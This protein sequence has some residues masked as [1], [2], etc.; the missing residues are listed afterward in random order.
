[1]DSHRVPDLMTAEQFAELPEEGPYR[2]E[3]KRGRIV[4]EPRPGA[5]HGF[6][7]AELVFHLRDHVKKNK[8]GRVFVDAGT[9]TERDPDTVRGP[10]ILFVS[11]ARLQAYPPKLWFGIA[12]E[13]C[14]EILSPSNRPGAMREKVAE[15]FAAGAR[16]VWIV[17]PMRERVTVYRSITD[18]R[19]LTRTEQLE[20]GDVLPGFQLPLAQLFDQSL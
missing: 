2:L 7:W 8:L 18:M 10:D 4:R 19:I 15:Y 5:D 1:M 12:P 14:V 6:I 16:L 17:E 13:L 20:G 9:I 3:L 11:R